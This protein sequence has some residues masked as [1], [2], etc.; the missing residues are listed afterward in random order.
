MPPKSK[1]KK[2]GGTLINDI[3]TLSIP[4]AILLAKQAIPLIYGKKTVKET[5][6]ASVK[7]IVASQVSSQVSSPKSLSRRKTI[8]GGNKK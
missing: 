8:A 4:F 2:E 3:A 5:K 6:Q 7:K 1:S